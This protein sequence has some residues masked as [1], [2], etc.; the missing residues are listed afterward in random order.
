MEQVNGF[1]PLINGFADRRLWPLGYTRSNVGTRR[2]IR[3]PNLLF[4]RQA[5][6]PNW[7]TRAFESADA[8]TRT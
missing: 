8:E 1:E 5:P 7:A 4:L 2:E 3:T 6:L